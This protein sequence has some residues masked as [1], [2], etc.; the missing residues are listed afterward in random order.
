MKDLAKLSE[1]IRQHGEHHRLK[2]EQ[3]RIAFL[4]A[5]ATIAACSAPPF[6]VNNDKLSRVYQSIS[7]LAILARQLEGETKL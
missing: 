1:T 2:L 6:S 5:V 3:E 7:S 4:E